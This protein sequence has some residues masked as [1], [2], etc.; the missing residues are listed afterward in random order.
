MLGDDVDE[1]EEADVLEEIADL[2]GYPDDIPDLR[3]KRHKL[4]SKPNSEEQCY[5][6]RLERREIPA[7]Y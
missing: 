2:L 6:A 3:R 5:F 1:L 4:S 7:I